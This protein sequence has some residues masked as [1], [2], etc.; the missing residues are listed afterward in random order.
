MRYDAINAMLLNEFLKE[1][2]KIEDQ[3]RRIQ[4][5]EATVAEL[6]KQLKL[7]VAHLEEQDTKVQGSE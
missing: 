4:E 7:L 5:Q 6:K 2:C 1:H 3:E